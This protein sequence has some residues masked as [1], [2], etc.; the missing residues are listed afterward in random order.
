[1]HRDSPASLVDG[2]VPAGQHP[3]V[4]LLWVSESRQLGHVVHLGQRGA[5]IPGSLNGW[6]DQVHG[7][8]AGVVD[9]LFRE[10]V[11]EVAHGRGSSWIPYTGSFG[12]VAVCVFGLQMSR[13]GPASQ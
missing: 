1:M 8:S 2:L 12:V 11:L 4:L 10:T 6:Q 13:K 9:R 7:R 5:V 3:L